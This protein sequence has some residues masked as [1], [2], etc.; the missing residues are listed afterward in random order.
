M[1]A[2]WNVLL[3][4]IS[5]GEHLTRERA[6]HRHAPLVPWLIIKMKLENPFANFVPLLVFLAD[7]R[8]QR[9]QKSVRAKSA[10]V[11]NTWMNLVSVDVKIVFQADITR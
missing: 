5:S 4:L 3:A 6:R 9:V 1:Y 10:L 8:T 7:S 2:E 11:G